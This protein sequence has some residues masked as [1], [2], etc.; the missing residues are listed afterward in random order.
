MGDTVNLASRLEG[1]NKVYGGRNPC[2]CGDWFMHR[3]PLLVRGAAHRHQNQLQP[4]LFQSEEFLGDE[5]FRK[6]RIAFQQDDGLAGRHYRTA[7]LALVRHRR[8][9]HKY[10]SWRRKFPLSVS[11]FGLAT[12]PPLCGGEESQCHRAAP[13]LGFLAHTKW[14]RGGETE[15]RDGEGGFSNQQTGLPNR[16]M[17]G[18][19][20]A[21]SVRTRPDRTHPSTTDRCGAGRSSSQSPTSSEMCTK[22]SSRRSG[23]DFDGGARCG[24]ALR[25]RRTACGSPPRP[26]AAFRSARVRTHAAPGST[27]P[28]AAPAARSAPA[29]R[30]KDLAVGVVAAHGDHG[31]RARDQLLHAVV[32]FEDLDVGNLRALASSFRRCFAGI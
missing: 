18:H 17:T 28:R 10:A 7:S 31:L 24:S 26:A 2:F 20:I 6:A 4:R 21:R 16:E 29:C 8:S 14:G 1:A 25:L 23:L 3:V 9:R 15:R 12:S 22:P 19:K 11:P 27:A 13:Q 5:R 30:R 32:E